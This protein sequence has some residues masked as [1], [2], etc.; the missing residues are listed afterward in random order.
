[1]LLWIA[2]AA[3]TGLA[4]LVLL[5]PLARRGTG[6]TPQASDVA[7]YKD[8]LA[9]I[10]RDLDR[11]LIAGGEAQAARIEVSRR[12]IEA[13]AAVETSKA[14][15]PAATS[16]TGRRRFAS[17]LI[18]VLVPV[19]SLGLYGFLGSPAKPDQP[20]LTRLAGS[21]KDA[22]DDELVARAEAKLAADPNNGAGWDLMARVYVGLGRFDDARQAY[23]NAIRLLGPTPERL[24]N[25]GV[26]LVAVANGM[27][28]ADAKSV[29]EQAL[30]RDPKEFRA[31]YFLG[32][33]RE[34]D[35]DKQGAIAAWQ[36]L[37]ADNPDAAEFLDKEIARVNG[38][39]AP[40][41][42]QTPGPSQ[43][44]VA[45]AQGLTPEERGKMIQAMVSRLSERLRSQGGSAE[46][47][48]QLVKAYTVINKAD[49]ARLALADA[50]KALASSPDAV[51]QLDDLSKALGL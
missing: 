15:A 32:V 44:D 51:K 38:A 29:F 22:S 47:W 18:L 5:W 1:M 6:M 41:S 17:M 23:T 13:D 26:T 2:L 24:A 31:N 49:E 45:N 9:E 7:I 11:G 50:R 25:Y 4:A 39:P 14:R 48:M 42:V 30:R 27:V 40:P 35:G 12:L 28:T 46:E 10:D 19:I 34:Q 3:M 21:T 33:A 43:E 16:A 8:Q 37:I 36:G 20:L